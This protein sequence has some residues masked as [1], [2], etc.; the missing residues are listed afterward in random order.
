[1]KIRRQQALHKK[2]SYSIK[3]KWIPLKSV[4][5]YMQRAVIAAEDDKFYTHFGFDFEALK[6]AYQRNERIN[7]I[8]LGGST[9]TQQ[10]AKN[11]FLSPKRSYWR[12]IREAV[13]TVMMEIFLSKR[14]I[15]EIYLN[16]I[17]WG[18]GIFGIEAAAQHYFGI[19]TKRLS[20]E[21]SCRLAAIIP[22]PLRYKINGSYV[23]YRAANLATIISGHSFIVSIPDSLE[24]ND[25]L[26]VNDTSK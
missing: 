7:S 19:S 18:P 17:E 13:V 22:S 20:L 9:I 16:S 2:K 6:K 25:S 8:K 5:L 1:M 26:K 3:H 12:K 21:Q 23:T 24:Q 14:R 10:L 15:L 11:L 4:P